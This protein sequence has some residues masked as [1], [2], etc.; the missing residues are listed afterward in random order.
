MNATLLIALAIA[1][2]TFVFFVNPRREKNTVEARKKMKHVIYIQMRTMM[3]LKREIPNL[4][5]R[6]ITQILK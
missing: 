5:K 3:V 2:L 6:N 4:Q 1:A